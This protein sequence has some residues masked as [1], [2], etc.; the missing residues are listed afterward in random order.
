MLCRAIASYSPSFRRSSSLFHSFFLW[1]S[2][3]V[4]FCF[5][6]RF[7][8]CVFLYL[9]CRCLFSYLSRFLFQ[10][11]TFCFFLPVFSLWFLLLSLP[12]FLSFFFDPLIVRSFCHYLS[13]FFVLSFFLSFF[14]SSLFIAFFP[15]LCHFPC[16]LFLAF[17][18]NS[19]LFFLPSPSSLLLS[20]PHT[21]FISLSLLSFLLYRFLL[22]SLASSFFSRFCSIS[23]LYYLFYFR[24]PCLTGLFLLILSLSLSLSLS[25]FPFYALLFSLRRSSSVFRPLNFVLSFFPFF[26]FPPFVLS[27]VLSSYL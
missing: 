19:Y 18:F 14:F 1:F 5:L 15:C 25:L 21:P 20:L 3:T 23:F 9:L 7:A 17:F 13:Y 6:Y 4:A 10:C 16:S 8:F 22:V 2:S 24:S 12:S 26:N 27:F 11:L